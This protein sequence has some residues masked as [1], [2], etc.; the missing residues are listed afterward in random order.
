[1]EW[2]HEMLLWTP[3]APNS[4]E[5]TAHLIRSDRQVG[6]TNLRG[7]NAYGQVAGEANGHR[8]LWTP[9]QPQGSIGA[10]TWLNDELDYVTNLND[11]GQVA[12]PAKDDQAALLWTPTQPH[13]TTGR[14]THIPK[15]WASDH[16]DLFRLSASGA[17]AGLALTLPTA[18]AGGCSGYARS[19][20]PR[21]RLTGLPGPTVRFLV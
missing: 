5:G 18:E 10:V 20:E 6:V 1:M 17:L 21:W 16:I 2:G 15:P 8:F 3:V 7:P 13:A 14:F 4:P 9:E 19:D 11:F 12:G